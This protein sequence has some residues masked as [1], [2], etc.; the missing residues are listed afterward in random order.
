MSS[1]SSWVGP[2]NICTHSAFVAGVTGEAH[3]GVLQF[4]TVANELPPRIGAELLRSVRN[5]GRTFYLGHG[6]PLEAAE[7]ERHANTLL[8]K[9]PPA[10]L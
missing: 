7:D 6:G 4:C 8:E 3:E 5:G 9:V 1:R 2:T 10:P